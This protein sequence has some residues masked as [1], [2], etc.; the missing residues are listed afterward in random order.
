VLTPDAL[1]R[2]LAGYIAE[3]GEEEGR[4]FFQQEW[5][6]SFNAAVLGTILAA[7]SSAWSRRGASMTR[8]V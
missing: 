3:F 6:C 7:I 2:E 8:R 5:Y 1:A 4:A